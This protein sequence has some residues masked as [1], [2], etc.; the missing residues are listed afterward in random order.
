MNNCS[1]I[2][3]SVRS[4]SLQTDDVIA[5][6]GQHIADPLWIRSSIRYQ[7]GSFVKVIQFGTVSFQG[8]TETV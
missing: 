4:M 3:H 1:V 8:G 2:E 7:A 5:N 6:Q